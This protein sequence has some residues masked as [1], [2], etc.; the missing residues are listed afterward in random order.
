MFSIDLLVVSLLLS[1][2]KQETTSVFVPYRK[3]WQVGGKE[4]PLAWRFRG[5]ALQSIPLSR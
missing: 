5:P 2:D 4:L 1:S 3:G